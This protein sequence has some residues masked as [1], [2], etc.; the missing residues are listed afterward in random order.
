MANRVV[1]NQAALNTFFRTEPGPTAALRNRAVAVRES[2]I[3]AAPKGVSLSWPKKKPGEPWIRRPMRHG[4]FKESVK[5]RKF[6][7]FWRVTAHDEF[8][9]MIEFGTVNNPAYS[10]FRRTVRNFGGKLIVRDT[11]E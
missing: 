1:I 10:P 9:R 8:A 2:V 11:D 5:L 7:N 3:E 6:R 4:R